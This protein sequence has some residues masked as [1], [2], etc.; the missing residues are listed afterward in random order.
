[1][2]RGCACVQAGREMQRK[3]SG[4][5]ARDDDFV[6]SCL[7]Q[8]SSLRVLTL[9]IVGV[10]HS[11]GSVNRMPDSCTALPTAQVLLA[12]VSAHNPVRLTKP[13]ASYQT[14]N[15]DLTCALPAT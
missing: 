3:L 6:Q 8:L 5:P 4:H 9:L 14:G 15:Q 2:R 13:F 10:K 7:S 1:M 12:F 11:S